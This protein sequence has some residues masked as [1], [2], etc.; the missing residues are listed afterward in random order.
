MSTGRRRRSRCGPLDGQ[1]PRCFSP[2][3]GGD[4]NTGHGAERAVA[5]AV[6]DDGGVRVRVSA[7]DPLDEVVLRSFCVGAAHM[8]LGWVTS[9]G[10]AV[11]ETGTPLDLTIRSFGVL[12]AVDT[13]PITVEIEDDRSSRATVVT[14]CS[15]RWRPGRGSRKA[16]HRGFPPEGCCDE[17]SE[18]STGRPSDR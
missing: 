17:P 2:G 8:A 18:A 3:R 11:G 15:P 5:E 10:L 12:R 7:G 4:T 1:R 16:A 6:V 14:Q 13:P 9:E